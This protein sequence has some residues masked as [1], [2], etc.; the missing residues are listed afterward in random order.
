MT[1]TSITPWVCIYRNTLPFEFHINVKILG[2]SNSLHLPRISL[3]ELQ[4]RHL[5][6]VDS[7]H[8]QV[9]LGKSPTTQRGVLLLGYHLSATIVMV[10]LF[11][12]CHIF[13]KKGISPLSVQIKSQK[14]SESIDNSRDPDIEY[15]LSFSEPPR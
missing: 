12:D 11:P 6:P 7:N 8:P 13:H 14:P 1:K 15:V 10:I 3:N 4:L 5:S 9:E 2:Y